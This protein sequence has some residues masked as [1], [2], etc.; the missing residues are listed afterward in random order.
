MSLEINSLDY[1]IDYMSDGDAQKLNPESGLVDFDPSENVLIFYDLDKKE[2]KFITKIKD[3]KLID[4]FL[5]ENIIA[6]EQE[7]EGKKCVIKISK[8]KL[9]TLSNRSFK[10]LLENIQ[11]E[12]DKKE[13]KLT[14]VFNDI[15]TQEPKS[16]QKELL[17]KAKQ[18]NTIIFLETGLGKTYIGIMLI[19]E[20][21]G[22]P[23]EANAK[24]E[25]DYVK[26]TDKKVLCLFQTVSLLLQQSKVI[27]HNTNLKILR[28]YGNAEKS[29]FFNHSKFNK[30][31]T[32]YDIICAT[33]ECIYRYF[34]FGY[35]TKNN[36]ELILI[37][38]CHHC[39]GDHFYNRV[40]SH[41]IFDTNDKKENEKVKIL[42]LTASPCEDG[43]L[44]E[45]K[46]KEKIIEL[47]N[48]MNCFIECP[49]NII[50][51]INE[52]NEKKPEFLN[53][54]Y[55]N[56]KKYVENITEVKNFLFHCF[57]MPFLDL[58][59]KKIYDKLTESYV[60]R[61]LIKPQK[62]KKYQPQNGEDEIPI[63]D[64]PY[65][66][67]VEKY[68]ELTQ[69]QKEENER[70]K[71]QNQ[72]NKEQRELIRNEIAMYILNFYLTLFIED[73]I[74]LDEKFLGIYDQNKDI[75][76]IKSNNNI[77]PDNDNN[78]DNSS[79]YNCYFNYF[80]KKSKEEK[81]KFNFINESTIQ[82]FVNKLSKEEETPIN[83][84][85]EMRNFIKE[86]K[87]DEI[88]KKFKHY[89]K[90][91]NLVIKFLDKEALLDMSTTKYFNY[92]FLNDFK[93][94]H[95]TEYFSEQNDEEGKD[96]DINNKDPFNTRITKMLSRLE[97]L[98]HDSKY[99]FK[100][101]YLDSLISF[102]TNEKHDNDKSILFINQR[103]ICEQFNK[104]LNAIFSNKKDPKIFEKKI[105]STYVLGISAS[106]NFSNFSEKNLKENIALFREDKNC[107]ILC[108]TNVVEEGIDIP[109]CNN[110]INLNE[111]RTI[112]EYIQKTGRARK[113]NSKLLLFSKKNDE[114]LNNS[115]IKQ[116]QLSIKVMNQMIKENSFEPKL[117]LRHYIQ[118]YNCFGT[119]EG[120]K[121]YYNYAPQIVNEFI[122]KL[123][124]DGYSYNR[125]KLDFDTTEDGKYI[126]YLLLP[127]V[128]ECDFQKIYDNSLNKFD[129]KEKATEYFNKYENYFYLKALI[130]LHH[131]G[132]LNHYLQFSK[133]YDSLMSYDE[134]FVKCP[135]ENKIEIKYLN[136]DNKS[137]EL[138]GYIIDMSPGY[139]NLTYN[140]EKKRH[141]LLLSQNPLTLLNF[142]LFL[143]T[144][145]LL[146]MYYFGKE[147]P[148][149]QD[150]NKNN[151]F[152]LKPKIP[153]TKFAKTNI[154]LGDAIK[155]KLT[156]EEIDLINF[157]YVYS[158][159]L[160]TD[161]ELF[162]YFCLYKNKIN[163]GKK[164]FQDDD[165]KNKLN[166]IF[167]KY[168]ENFF[169]KGLTKYHLLNYKNA[170][171]NYQNHLVKYTFALYDPKNKNY[172]IDIKYIKKCYKACINDLDEYYK[173]AFYCI[174]DESEK[175][176][177]L[178][179]EEY[180]E[181]QT[182]IVTPKFENEDGKGLIGP[183]LMVRN[184]MNFSKYMIM[185]YGEKNL[186]GRTECSRIKHY[187]NNPTY[188]KYYLVK[189]GI[190]TNKRHD[191]LK[192]S[193]L[194]Y[195]LKLT[196]YKVNLTSLGKVDKK[197]GQFRY[198]KKF[199]FF[200]GE[201]LSQIKFMTIDQ[202]YMYTL[203]PTILFKLQ[204]SLIYY[205]NAKCLFDEFKLSI[206]TL[207][208]IDIKLIMSCLNSKST[209][210]IENYERLEFLGD[211]ILK[212]LSSIQLF[213]LYPNANRDLL[214]SLRR[215]IE[216]NQFLFEKAKNKNLEELLFTSP[217]TIKRMRI[218]GF[219]RDENLIFDIGYNRSFSKNC[220]KH[221]I[222][223]KQK[224]KIEDKN[225]KENSEDKKLMTEEEKKKVLK[226]DDKENELESEIMNDK[227][228]IEVNYE[229]NVE[230]LEKISKLNVNLEQINKIC[231][232]QIEIIPQPN[233]YRYI[234]TKTLADI[235]ESLTAFTYISALE[236]Y[237][238]DKYDSALELTTK[239]LK[240]MDVIKLNYLDIID[241]ITKIAVQHVKLN[242]ECKFDEVK[243]DKYLE[244][245]IKNKY[246]NFKNK[247]LAYQA[248]THPSMLAEENL[249]KKINYVNKSYQRLAFLGEAIVEL[250][251][252]IFVYKNNPYEMESNLH[253]MRI[254][255]INHHIISLIAFDLKFHDCLL[256]PSGGGFKTDIKKYTEKLQYERNKMKNRYQLPTDEL[257]NEEFVIILCELFHAY[258]GAIFVDS[259]D[260][261]KTFDVLKS[262][263][264]DYLLN[265]ATKDTYKE[266]PKE[267]ILNEYM[268]KRHFIKSLRENGANRII[269]KY[270]KD[271][272]NILPYRKRKMYNYQLIIN[273][274]II[275]KENIAYSRPSIKRAQ[276]KAKN[277]F[278]KV[279]GEIDRRL[280]LRMNEQNKHFDIRNI[281]EYLGIIYEEAN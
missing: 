238:E 265:N 160:S 259:H 55:P 148:F 174:K 247:I 2:Q 118:N 26:K 64:D 114:F 17:E 171:L 184:L 143:P 88:L 177:L 252:S 197:W 124:N 231:E 149:N 199:P 40:L 211:A 242:E 159:F 164:L 214:F 7:K 132:Y 82:E 175:N 222:I 50:G 15:I 267:I 274:L 200:P 146:T 31:L 12:F 157:F 221:K 110:V 66:E 220:F 224:E 71:K 18:K 36:F 227:I 29:A 161:A 62:I 169:Q 3:V 219:T 153:Y 28:L 223:M 158:L 191:Y 96:D 140:E 156:E 109:D 137:L 268:K 133:N 182:D 134:K 190:L 11:N 150:P 51:E 33:P 241:N 100:S 34:T 60:D 79:L 69:E 260:I 81:T 91:A 24:K 254:C 203:M 187:Y 90:S 195:N 193:P 155:I 38:E 257:D 262:I 73:E 163:F 13:K 228:S 180:L 32:H 281:L 151:W 89:T 6:F 105:K 172:S 230:P 83:F 127:S 80:R 226:E 255:G 272:N 44:E 188:Q 129:T 21:F 72:D 266:H 196:K 103:I 102:I 139:I 58:H 63:M 225:N 233:V 246:Y 263:M 108:A 205:Y 30:T 250:Y 251:V 87:E 167:E 84:T 235:V 186:T 93:E 179:D 111:M 234:Y 237:G 52:K 97:E 85:N 22:E 249:Q 39:K 119:K 49:K 236:N 104:K 145:I 166:Y 253:K 94:E 125:T 107:K 170:V 112:K 59:F 56:E 269:L 4:S 35:L 65:E 42:G 162:F 123:Y 106:N 53:V 47:C 78:N 46:I 37:D 244:L 256:S 212:F 181:E 61:K 5:S 183:G 43:V 131:N 176:K 194:N 198:I 204:S 213:N 19:K 86:I 113:E 216:N 135:S 206:G 271:N 70:I 168:D 276:E 25:I 54:D 185:N 165:F 279:C 101:P 218:P 115:R 128:L 147:E 75:S 154:N 232:E 277:I 14:R 120:A 215:D 67:G 41:F 9:D 278:L 121:V 68:K 245:V 8:P 239:Y 201:V 92:E 208:E 142:D 273:G 126:P 248:M 243:R 45:E 229:N 264:E 261:K 95:L 77:N 1:E 130:Y 270:Q 210:E 57:I 98:N 23:L 173:F 76:L 74:K 144:R 122:S 99:D 280:K 116:I 152:Q 207:K 240:E 209:L 117:P 192:C 20:I 10:I 138:I 258:I 217:R 48:N 189:Y 16:Y 275:Y 27:K 141:V 202:L 136:Q 178:S